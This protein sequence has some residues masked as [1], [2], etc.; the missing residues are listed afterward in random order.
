M[1]IWK[2]ALSA[3]MCVYLFKCVDCTEHSAVLCGMRVQ[4]A[5]AASSCSTVVLQTRGESRG[6]QSD[7]WD[8]DEDRSCVCCNAWQHKLQILVFCML[9]Q[10]IWSYRS[11]SICTYL[12]SRV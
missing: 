2:Q 12:Y 1:C 4:C 10:A 11:V 6:K 8:E 3:E 5:N 7:S 9:L